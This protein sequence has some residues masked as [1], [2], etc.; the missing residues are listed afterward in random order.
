LVAVQQAE[1]GVGAGHAIEGY[2][3]AAAVVDVVEVVIDPFL[4]VFHL[5]FEEAGFD[6]GVAAEAPVG[7]G[8]L[9]DEIELGLAAGVEVGEVVVE[10]G[11]VFGARFGGEDDGLGGESVGEGVERGGG[12]AGWGDG[13]GGFGAVGAG[14]GEFAV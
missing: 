7:G 3:D 11:F 4:V 14:G 13:A 8:E 5:V 9:A 6:G 10:L 12:F 1:G 2:G